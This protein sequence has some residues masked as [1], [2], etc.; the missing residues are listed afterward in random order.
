[1]GVSGSGKS[2]LI[3]D[4]LYPIIAAR[5][6]RTTQRRIG[7]HRCIKGLQHLDKVG[8]IDQSPIGR[9]PRSNLATY[10]SVF[11]PIRELFAG[12]A[13]ARLRGYLPGRF[14]FNVQSGRCEACE[15]D[16]V[17]KVEMHF[18]ADSYV[19]CDTCKGKRYNRETLE[20]HYKGKN[21]YDV[22]QMTVEEACEFC[23][24]IPV[25]VRKL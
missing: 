22:L 3:S 24:A 21:I 13:E 11:T 19:S 4:T 17:I 14:S 9:T 5:L 23:D 1:M 18:L 10:T 16:G 12:T 25:I 20:I 15:G 8:E 7:P 2:S 6:N